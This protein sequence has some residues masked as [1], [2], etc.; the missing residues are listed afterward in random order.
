MA[1]VRAV[2]LSIDGTVSTTVESIE[3]TVSTTAKSLS[4]ELTLPTSVPDYTGEYNVNPDFV[5][6]ILSTAGKLLTQNVNVRPIQVE[7]VSNPQGGRTVYI[8][9]IN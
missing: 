4:G 9:G 2:Y 1:D 7:N 8:G 3:G 5:G 6:T